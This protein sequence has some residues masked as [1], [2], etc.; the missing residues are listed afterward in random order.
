MHMQCYAR[1]TVVNFPLPSYN[2]SMY[3]TTVD[4]HLVNRAQANYELAGKSVDA[5]INEKNYLFEVSVIRTTI[6]TPVK[7][8]ISTFQADKILPSGF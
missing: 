4:R 3:S 7:P 6:M 2:Y 1:A 5:V 8:Q